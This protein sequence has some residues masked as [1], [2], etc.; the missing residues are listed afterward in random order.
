MVVRI[1]GL[2][3][4]FVLTILTGC[5]TVPEPNKAPVTTV[6]SQRSI[7]SDSA[8]VKQRLLGH[9]GE[10]KGTPYVYG[11]LS[12]K[13]IDCSGFVHLTFLERL[14]LSIPRETRS[15]V[16][17]GVKVAP[18]Q[19]QVGDLV[20]FKTG[21]NTRH[22]GI[23]LGDDQFLPASTSHGVI[24]SFLTNPYWQSHFW[25]ARRVVA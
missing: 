25:Q 18:R 24:I 23:Y 4:I 13:G 15:Q 19:M 5:S 2:F 7:F 6:N 21:F 10:W 20:F 17:L 1:K 22:V 16:K 9:Y 11:G 14:G 8:V 12:T 3:L